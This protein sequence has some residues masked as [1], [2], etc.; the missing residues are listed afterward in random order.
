MKKY[1]I[2]TIL[3]LSL[4]TLF[5]QNIERVEVNGTVVVKSE[6]LEGVTIYNTSSNK[7]TIT[8]IAGKFKIKVTLNDE[9]EISAL[10]FSPTKITITKE[11]L[12]AKELKVFLA[13]RINNL[14]EVVVLQND[15]TGIL[16]SD[17]ENVKL[18]EYVDFGF[19]SFN[20][21]DMSADYKSGVVNTAI[22]QPNLYQM[23]FLGI[24]KLIVPS[25]FEVKSRET[26]REVTQKRLSKLYGTKLAEAFTHSYYTTNYNIPEDKVNSF[27]A[28][29]EKAGFNAEL[30]QEKN[31]LRLIE[32]LQEKSKQYLNPK[33]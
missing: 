12:E 14:D 10:Q 28:F 3:L 29:V 18:V 9:I 32:Y 6:D 31:E 17:V 16:E 26:K 19:G 11:I 21:Y 5:S 25:L 23:N 8:D 27:I 15:L 33:N 4:T 7:G 30:L 22:R 24:V 2:I 13:E 20:D 1:V